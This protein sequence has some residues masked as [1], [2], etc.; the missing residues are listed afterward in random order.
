MTVIKTKK[1]LPICQRATL[2]QKNYFKDII[3][4]KPQT[5]ST[6]N[7]LL[8]YSAVVNHVQLVRIIG[9]NAL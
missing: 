8:Q 9:V 7:S 4:W 2:N 6:I 5:L 3:T 1:R